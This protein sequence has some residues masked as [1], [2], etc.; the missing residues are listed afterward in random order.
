MNWDQNRSIIASE[1]VVLTW[2]LSSYLSEI[3]N[4]A[5]T[6]LN[7]ILIGCEKLSQERTARWLVDTGEQWEGN[8][9]L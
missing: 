8:F 7:Q 2:K 9:L 6:L 1:S 4:D 5:Y 3:P